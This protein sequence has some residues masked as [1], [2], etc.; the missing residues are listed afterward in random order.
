MIE[1]LLLPDIA[2]TNSVAKTR[3]QEVKLACPVAPL[4]VLILLELKLV[5]R[6]ALALDK[7]YFLLLLINQ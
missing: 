5:P 3:E 2:Q 7:E 1:F 4:R 6:L